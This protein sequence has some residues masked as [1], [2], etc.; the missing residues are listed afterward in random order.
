MLFRFYNS[1]WEIIELI[2][3]DGSDNDDNP[4]HWGPMCSLEPVLGDVQ[5]KKNWIC[6]DLR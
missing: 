2:Y 4:N 3:S 5:T 1:G 6:F